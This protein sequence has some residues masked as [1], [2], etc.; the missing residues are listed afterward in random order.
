MC[1]LLVIR[2]G[3]TLLIYPAELNDS[4]FYF[5]KPLF[6]TDCKQERSW[7]ERCGGGGGGGAEGEGRSPN[8][9]GGEG[10]GRL[11]DNK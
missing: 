5:Q 4:K 7:G 8:L 10:G 6:E 11:D 9:K 2:T 1:R 3:R